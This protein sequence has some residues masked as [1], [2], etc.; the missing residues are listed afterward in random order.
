MKRTRFR[1]APWLDTRAQFVAGTPL[2]EPENRGAENQ[3]LVWMVN[4]L[5]QELPNASSLNFLCN[6]ALF[7]GERWAYQKTVVCSTPLG[8]VAGTHAL[9]SYDDFTDARK[10]S[11]GGLTQQ[12]QKWNLRSP[13]PKHQESGCSRLP[14]R[15]LCLR[16]PVGITLPLAT[17]GLAG[18]LI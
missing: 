11:M 7:P 17:I 14:I 13:S 9:A 4:N 1:Y 15:S 18:P 2:R 5:H 12:A 8:R 16:L 10:V 6:G 3:G